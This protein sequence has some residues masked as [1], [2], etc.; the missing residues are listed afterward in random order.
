MMTSHSPGSGQVHLSGPVAVAREQSALDWLLKA[1][2]AR[3]HSR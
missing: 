1:S 2:P 3:V